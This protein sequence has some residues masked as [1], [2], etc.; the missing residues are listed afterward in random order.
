MSPRE[1]PLDIFNKSSFL[2]SE[3]DMTFSRRGLSYIMG[4]FYSMGCINSLK[5]LYSDGITILA[6]FTA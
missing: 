1:T 6:P 3:E 5:V 2:L 4:L